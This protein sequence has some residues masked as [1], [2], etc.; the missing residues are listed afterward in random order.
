MRD[1]RYGREKV[2]VRM[3]QQINNRKCR[4][5]EKQIRDFVIRDFVLT[6]MYE[7]LI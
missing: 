5:E 3:E 1:L 4:Q 7:D 2:Q 6:V